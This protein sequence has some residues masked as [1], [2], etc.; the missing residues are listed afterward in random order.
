MKPHSLY[1]FLFVY[2]LLF[3]TAHFRILIRCAMYIFRALCFF[4][5]FGPPFFFPIQVREKT[6][7]EAAQVKASIDS[8]LKMHAQL[9]ASKV[10][11]QVRSATSQSQHLLLA[12]HL[13][14]N[15][16]SLPQVSALVGKVR[17]PPNPP[18][19]PHTPL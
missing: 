3:H 19:T 5:Q 11:E 14:E 18:L 17:V 2:P 16:R 6:L 7:Q 9:Q 10:M 4:S 12:S 15:G 8:A 13:R 1:P